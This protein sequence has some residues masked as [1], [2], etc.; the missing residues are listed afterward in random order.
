MKKL[1]EIQGRV[2]YKVGDFKSRNIHIYVYI[3]IYTQIYILKI[4]AYITER[5]ENVLTKKRGG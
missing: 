5:G 4:Y 1:V 2:K 3:Y